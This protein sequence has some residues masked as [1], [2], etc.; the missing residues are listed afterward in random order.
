MLNTKRISERLETAALSKL[1]VL[2]RHNIVRPIKGHHKIALK[3]K[4]KLSRYLDRIP[5]PINVYLVVGQKL[6]DY[7]N[8]PS[9]LLE[10][11]YDSPDILAQKW[12]WEIPEDDSSMNV[13]L[14]VGDNGRTLNTVHAPTAWIILHRLCH[15]INGR[16]ITEIEFWINDILREYYGAAFG[17]YDS[18]DVIDPVAQAMF[19]F[20]SAKRATIQNK[21]EL[22][23]EIVTYTIV[24][25]FKP[26]VQFPGMIELTKKQLIRNRHVPKGSVNDLVRIVKDCLEDF[27]KLRGKYIVL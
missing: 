8:R 25:N 21:L 4:R 7:I 17:L 20:G 11:P 1:R 18:K 13:F 6:D 15:Y 26:E 2:D 3:G 19:K 12:G 16:K 14:P 5:V 22:L 24:K 10:R 23:V 27:E 9:S